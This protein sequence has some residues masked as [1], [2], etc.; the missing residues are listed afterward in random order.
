MAM[1]VGE[2]E[3]VLRDTE[4]ESLLERARGLIAILGPGV[5]LAAA[6]IGT[7]HFLLAPTAG[8]AYGYALAWTVVLAHAVKYPA[9]AYASRYTYATGESIVK[10][11]GRL[12]GPKGLT[13]GFLGVVMALEASAI[14]AGVTSVAASAL[15]AGFPSVPYG[16]AVVGVMAACG[17]L[18]WV[19]A[20]KGMERAAVGMLA[21]FALL[22]LIVGIV[23]TPDLGALAGGV[24]VPSVPAGSALLAA[25]LLGYMP[26]PLELAILKSL[27]QVERGLPEDDEER[28]AKTGEAL[29]DFR[30]GYVTSIVLGLLLIGLGAALLAPRGLVPEGTAVIATISNIYGDALGSGTVPLYLGAAFLGM[31]AT[32]LAVIDGYPRGI[33]HTLEALGHDAKKTPE[34]RDIRYWWILYATF[35]LAVAIAVFLPDPAVLV[36]LAAAATVLLAPIWYTLIVACVHRLPEEIGPPAWIRGWAWVGLAGMTFTAGLVAW[37]SFA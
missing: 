21:V 15:L 17:T 9:F 28:R 23:A 22:T 27:W 10:G 26:A 18:L 19:G 3:V 35:A 7:S 8:A 2:R 11:F 13:L 32:V 6:G 31:F 24:I 4:E 29:L 12:P 20:Y 36:S 25:G 30:L 5:L 33:S 37:L 16:F 14:L 1:E 34:G